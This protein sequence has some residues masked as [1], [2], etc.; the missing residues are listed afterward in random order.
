MFDLKKRNMFDLKKRNSLTLNSGRESR[1]VEEFRRVAVRRKV[2]GDTQEDVHAV[3]SSSSCGGSCDRTCGPKH[4]NHQSPPTKPQVPPKPAHLQSP[5]R[6]GPPSSS[7]HFP[8][9]DDK[10]PIRAGVSCLLNGAQLS[11]TRLSPSQKIPKLTSSPLGS[12]SPGKRGIQNCT[13]LREGGH[14]PAKLTPR[15]RSP[16]SVILRTPSPVQ[17]KIGSY[18][19]ARNSKSWLG[20]HRTPSGKMEGWE[21]RS[22]KSLSVPD[23]VVYLDERIPLEKEESSPRPA[24]TVKAPTDCRL[25]R[26]AGEVSSQSSTD[27]R[28]NRTVE[29]VSSH[30]STDCRLNRTVEEVSSQSSTDCRLNSTVG[31]VSSQS[32][33][34]CRLNRTVGEVSSQSSTDCRLNS[35]VGEVS[36]Q[37]LTDCRLNRTVGEVSS[38]PTDCR[39]NR[40]VGEVSSCPTDCRL[41]RTVGKVSSQSLTDCRLNRT[42]GKVSSQSLTDCRLNRTVGEVSSQS[43]TDCRLNR[44]VGEVSSRPTDCRLNR[45]V[46]EVSS[47]PTDCRLNRTVEEVSPRPTDCRLNR[48]V[49][50]VSPRPTDCR[51]NRTVEEVSPRPTAC[52]LNHTV[53]EVSS[54]PTDCRLNRTV[55]K[56][57]SQ[58]STDQ[59]QPDGVLLEK[60]SKIHAGSK[61]KCRWT[62]GERHEEEEEEEKKE[63][64]S[65]E[66]ENTEQKLFKIARELLH[67]ERAYVARLH[68][69]DQVFC[70][71]LTEEAGR[72]SFPAEVVRN[73]FSNIS[74]IYS[75]HSQFL[76]PDL[77]D[78][79]SHWCEQPGLG[80]VLLHHAPFLRMYADYVSNFQPA[81]ELLRTWTERS[82]TF[83]NLLHD[84]QSQD[85]CGSL[86]LQHHMLEPVQRIPRYEMLLRDYVKKMPSTHP[87]YEFAQRSLETISMAANHSNSA[88]HKAESIKRLLEIYEMVGEEDV[89]NPT[90]QFVKEGRLLKISAR[91]T[92]SMERHLFLFNNFLL[93]CTPKFSLVG[94]RLTVR[95]RI[96][97]D[98]MQ[99]QQT[100]NED[101]HYTFQV[102]GKEKTLELQASSEQD[103]DE[104]IQVIQD[105]IHEFQQKNQTFKMASK[106]IQAQEQTAELGRRAPRWVRDH[107][108]TVCK[109]CSE[110]FNALTRRRHHCRA[111]GCVVC[112][113]CSDHKVALEY[114]GYKLN[115][116][117]KSCFS[118][119]SAPRGGGAKKRSPES[120]SDSTM[121]GFLQYGDHPRRCQQVWGVV[122]TTEAPLLSLYATPQD[123]APLSRIPLAG[124]TVGEP[125]ADLQGHFCLRH[126]QSVHVF[127]CQG[128]DLK[129]RWVGALKAAVR[130]SDDGTSESS[131]EE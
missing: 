15:N 55:G 105:A 65:K 12:P 57:S 120:C 73:I 87:D 126:P 108:V 18:S 66:D 36:S 68:L 123:P 98:G 38:C 117:C 5:M 21:K 96:G 71:R 47:R 35:T 6:S 111:C 83:R 131:G 24:I 89:V 54:R 22:G 49:E 121:S 27:C 39:L 103:R 93:C 91:N 76:L 1:D 34:D 115:K 50:E 128:D 122:T 119:L 19:P 77:E 112:W 28:L 9:T 20:V 62:E 80:E 70:L 101:H 3:G 51:L 10:S 16:L 7:R 109:T 106:E 42:V 44:S 104:W 75:F 113:R 41:N 37:S 72:G 52:R 17:N 14:C 118:V 31:E 46:G 97:V 4:E 92:S 61:S 63:E 85:V 86:T 125:P 33:T 130:G 78:R 11:P 127:S 25:N 74:S 53:G 110:S 43:S 116:V 8:G 2:K 107:Q 129:R 64:A 79:I 40:T 124:C 102:S 81:M 114:D 94:Q 60:A 58:S 29:E 99:V 56:V 69:L 30:S 32:L 100:T 90:N 45:T 67:T 82:S 88:L 59:R 95:S 48:T 84:I 23:L 13:P 26:T